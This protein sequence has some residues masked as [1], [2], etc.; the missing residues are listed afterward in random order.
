[1]LDSMHNKNLGRQGEN[2]A[3]NYYEKQGWELITQNKTEKGSE[4]DLVMG[5]GCDSLKNKIYLDSERNT[6]QNDNPQDSI[7]QETREQLPQYMKKEILFIEVKTLE[8][9]DNPTLTAEDNFTKTKQRN[10][11]RGIELYLVK[12]KIN[13]DSISIRIDLAC[14]YHHKNNDKWTIKVHNNIILD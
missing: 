10:F 4:L 5:R 11:R 13:T 12:N 2:L 8:I 9:L 1:M 14:V 3:R 6:Y 7:S